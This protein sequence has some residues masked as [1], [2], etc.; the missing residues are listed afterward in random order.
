MYWIRLQEYSSEGVN[1]N[2]TPM[3][4][5]INIMQTLRYLLQYVPVASM[6]KQS[7]NAPS[8][9]IWTFQTKAVRLLGVVALI[10]RVISVNGS[11]PPKMIKLIDISNS[12]ICTRF[13]T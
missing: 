1:E 4:S 2:S 7:R 3:N 13:S 9:L 5:S 8:L 6:C 10:I 12:H 11:Y